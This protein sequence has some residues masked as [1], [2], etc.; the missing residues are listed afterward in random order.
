MQLRI[1]LE[2]HHF[3]KLKVLIDRRI[4]LFVFLCGPF[5]NTTNNLMKSKFSFS[6]LIALFAVACGAGTPSPSEVA[7][8]FLTHTNKMEFAEA[9]QYSSKETSEMLDMLANFAS[10]MGEQEAPKPFKITGE[11][12]DGDNATVSYRSEGDELDEKINLIKVDGKWLVNVSKEDLDK[13]NAVDEET[14]P[15]M[16]WNEDDSMEVEMNEEMELEEV[17]AL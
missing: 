7:E 8:K 10:Q 1:K 15:T 6:V 9:K 13:E 11:N 4:V 2:G 12:I 16:D 17:P 14:E 5:P 3:C